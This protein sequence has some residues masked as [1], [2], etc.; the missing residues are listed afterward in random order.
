M[1]WRAQFIDEKIARDAGLPGEGWYPV[2]EHGEAHP[3]RYRR[4]ELCESWIRGLMPVFRET[5][6]SA[7]RTTPLDQ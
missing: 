3:F 1:T 7:A 5:A 4:R 6:T 2:N